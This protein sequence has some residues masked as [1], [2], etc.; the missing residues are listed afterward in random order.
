M[1][2]IAEPSHHD[3]QYLQANAIKHD[4]AIGDDDE[5]RFLERVAI[6]VEDGGLND[7]DARELA[8]MGIYGIHR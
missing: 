2:N 3:L 6:A 8:F 1:K 7:N 4:V 5:Y